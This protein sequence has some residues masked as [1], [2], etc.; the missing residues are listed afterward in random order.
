MA[1]INGQVAIITGSGSGIG[2][3][4]ARRLASDG[5][6]IAV[7]DVDEDAAAETVSL[8]K[9]DGGSAFSAVADVTNL[10]N[11]REMVSDV[12]DEA[13]GVDI[14]VNNAGWDEMQ[15]FLEQDPDVWDRI[16]DI[17]FRGQINCARAVS[18]VMTEDN[19]G[20]IVNIASDA[21]RAG[22]T[23]EAVYSGAKGGVISFSK[24]LAR[25]LA[26]DG[27]RVNVVAPGPTETP[28]VDEMRED[29]D[30][31]EKILG[32]M[33]SQIPLGRMAEPEDI[34]GAVAFL[35]SDDASFVTGQVLSVSGGLT[36][37]D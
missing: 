35:V 8:I 1:N 13:G 26:R 37:N 30:L 4:I 11:V 12:I 14:L 3:A 2:R 32:S 21:G 33:A 28:L 34:A 16:I 22:S 20:R 36:M 17:N 19:G 29:S 24:T 15:W 5:A 9:E 31:G 18:E 6:T 7:N 10:K 27:V 25:E 23:G